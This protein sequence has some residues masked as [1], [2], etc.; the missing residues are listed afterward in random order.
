LP[1]GAPVD[2]S[3]LIFTG[4]PSKSENIL[5]VPKIT[6]SFR[7]NNHGML[8]AENA[9]I[10]YTILTLEKD[11]TQNTSEKIKDKDTEGASEKTASEEGA[12]ANGASETQQEGEAVKKPEAEKLMEVKRTKKSQLKVEVRPL[13]VLP[14]QPKE[15]NDAKKYLKDL[16]RADKIKRETEETRN[17]IET[18]VYDAQEKLNEDEDL[19][20]FTN[21]AEKEV[22]F[23]SLQQAG[24]WLYEEGDSATFDV[25]KTKLKDLR[26]QVDKIFNRRIEFEKRKDSA[27]LLIGTILYARN[28]TSN[29]TNSHE[30]EADEYERFLAYLTTEEQELFRL[31]DLQQVRPLDQDPLFTSAD[32][33]RKVKEIQRRARAFKLRPKRKPKVTIEAGVATEDKGT[34][35]NR[36]EEKVDE[37]KGEKE[38][39]FEDMK[40]EVENGA[41]AGQN[42]QEASQDLQDEL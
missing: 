5:D 3:E 17:S 36:T 16:D 25:L 37:K 1:Q 28:D 40:V 30:V 35:D 6:L 18:L 13:G 11:P 41:E 19:Q 23:E 24:N 8:V 39:V 42:D 9:E 12:S 26:S 15:I 32:L 4:F 22:V 34:E 14:L 10:E 21:D 2:I 7:L 20:R 38:E 33:D 31:Y 27:A 29:I